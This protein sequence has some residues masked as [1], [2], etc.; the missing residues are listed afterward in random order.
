MSYVATQARAADMIAEKG[1]SVTL[2]RHAGGAYDTAT[3]EVALVDTVTTTKGVLLPLP[4]G[5]THL[6]GTNIRVGDQQLLLPGDITAPA[7]DDMVS[8]GGVAYTIIE[9]SPLNPG[10]TNLLYDCIVRGA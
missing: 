6:A 1:R 4:R 9:V 8:I 7:I 5:F 3:G 2:T 10:G